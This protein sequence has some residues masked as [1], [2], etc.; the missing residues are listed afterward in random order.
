MILFVPI[1][2]PTAILFEMD[3]VHLGL[4]IVITLAIGLVTPPYGLCLLLAAKIGDLSIEKSL[5]A[6]LPYIFIILVV[7]L[8]VAFFPG[9]AFFLPK[10]INP[11]LFV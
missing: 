10:L 3:T 5:V 1:I 7:L 11:G 4:I 6:I 9:I 2:L 8:F